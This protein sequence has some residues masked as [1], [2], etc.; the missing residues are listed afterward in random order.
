MHKLHNIVRKVALELWL[1]FPWL[2]QREEMH[3]NLGRMIKI[4]TPKNDQLIHRNITIREYIDYYHLVEGGRSR[5]ELVQ[6]LETGCQV[7]EDLG[8]E[9]CVGRGTLLGLHRDGEFLPADHDIDI[10]VYSEKQFFEIIR[11]MPFDLMV[12]A[13][14]DQ[15]GAFHQLSFLDRRTNIIFD[16][17]IYREKVSEMVAQMYP[18]TFRLPKSIYKNRA[19][20]NVDGREYPVYSPEEYCRY[21]Y[22][23]DYRKPKSYSVD[24]IP[25]YERDCQGFTHDPTN[26]LRVIKHFE[27]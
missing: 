24:W 21:W 7:L 23:N 1:R 22:G 3:R 12:V 20:I 4:A 9:Y 10:D 18:G 2:K 25:H 14:D 13:T 27:S 19:S 5:K 15:C 8:V 26:V 16:I 11:K 6:C 17:W